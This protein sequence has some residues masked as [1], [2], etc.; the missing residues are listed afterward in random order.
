MLGGAAVMAAGC[1]Y[2]PVKRVG[3]TGGS[4]YL[5]YLAAA[6]LHA[7]RTAGTQRCTK[8]YNGKIARLACAVLCFLVIALLEL[9]FLQELKGS[10]KKRMYVC[11]YVCMYVFVL[12]CSVEA[13]GLHCSYAKLY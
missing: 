6:L 10:R 13:G 5:A 3:T 2:G 12:R 7:N 11:M 1:D 4:T 8:A 9:I